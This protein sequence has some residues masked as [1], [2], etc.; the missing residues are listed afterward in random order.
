MGEG[1]VI[2]F[3]DNPDIRQ[4]LEAYRDRL[5]ALYADAPKELFR[6]LVPSLGPPPLQMSDVHELESQ[7]PVPLPPSFVEYLLGPC[8]D[9]DVEWNEYTITGNA[10]LGELSS[11]LLTDWMWPLGYLW[12]ANG[13][14]GDPVCFDIQRSGPEYPVVTFNH[15]GIPPGAMQSRAL[16]EPHVRVLAP[17]FGTFLWMLTEYSA[18]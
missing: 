14:S 5:A 9:N 3:P 1:E 17:T 13:P 10:K 6:D 4:S 2:Q 8:I 18:D 12:F 15:D 11:T 7:L 16:L